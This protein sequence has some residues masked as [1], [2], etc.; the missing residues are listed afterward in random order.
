MSR[1]VQLR[2]HDF[3]FVPVH[4]SGVLGQLYCVDEKGKQCYAFTLSQQNQQLVLQAVPAF[5]PS[6][7][8]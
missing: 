5:F 6:A 2:V 8:L 4:N 3:A 1:D 7:P